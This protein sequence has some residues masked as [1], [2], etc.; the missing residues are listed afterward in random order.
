MYLLAI[1]GSPN[2]SGNTA[3]LLEKVLEA[4]E[5]V[6]TRLLH[7]M[8][9]LEGQKRPY[10]IACSSPCREVCHEENALGEAV[11]MLEGAG[12]VVLGSPVYFGTVSG[13]LKSFWDKTRAVRNRRSLIGKPGAG[14]TV[15]AS[16][17]GGQE[18][19]LRALH[20]MLLVHG[21]CVV[22][23]GTISDDGGHHGVCAQKPSEQDDYAIERAAILGRRMALEIKGIEEIKGIKGIEAGG[24]PGE[25]G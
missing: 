23:D 20:D 10:C 4:A 6:E 7:V 15:G 8:D 21:M 19:T 22:G 13:Q 18:T 5:G 16:R 17:F 1:N 9:I 14:V 11:R 25:A 2:R 3:F 12:G 24:T